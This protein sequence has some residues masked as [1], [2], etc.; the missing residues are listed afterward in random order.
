ML[1][2][3]QQSVE[4][5]VGVPE[6]ELSRRSLAKAADELRRLG[7]PELA[8]ALEASHLNGR[9]RGQRLPTT[10]E[11]RT[12]KVQLGGDLD[13][14]RVPTKPIGRIRG[15]RV[16]SHFCDANHQVMVGGQLITGPFVVVVPAADV[17][18][19]HE[20]EDDVDEP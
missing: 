10:G 17:S 19:G 3:A 11:M 14:A 5:L 4:A 16:H 20:E 1:V 15:Q 6:G 8:D 13:F 9:R 12:Y 7:R 18:N 2:L